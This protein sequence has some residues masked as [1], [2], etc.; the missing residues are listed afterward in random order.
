MALEDN[1]L[2]SMTRARG[3]SSSSLLDRKYPHQVL[4]L[5]QKVVGKA[6]DKVIAF[7]AELGVPVKTHSIR[8]D[9]RWYLLYC[10]ADQQHAARFQVEFGGEII[11]QR[12]EP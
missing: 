2:I 6:L 7:H 4:V 3:Q 12:K 11:N 10:F 9:D 5:A 8:K 1:R